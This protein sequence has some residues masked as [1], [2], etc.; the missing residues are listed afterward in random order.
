MADLFQQSFPSDF[1]QGLSF[2]CYLFLGNHIID[3]ARIGGTDRWTVSFAVWAPDAMAVQV[4]GSFNQWGQ[5]ADFSGSMQPVSDGIWHTEISGISDG[6]L[7]VYQITHKDGSVHRQMDPFARTCTLHPENASVIVDTSDFHWTDGDWKQARTAYSPAT[8]PINIYE[9]HL[10][11]WLRNAAYRNYRSIAD[12]LTHYLQDMHYTH[13]SLTSL[14]EYPYDSSFGYHVGCFYAVTGRYGTP[15][16]FKYLVNRLH[17]AGIGVLMDWVP[18][19]FVKDSNWLYRFGGDW[20]YESSIENFRENPYL[21]TISF[22][23]SKGPV[24]SFLISN[25]LFWL[26]E[27]H[28]DGLCIKS[29]E[30]VLYHDFGRVH[31][32]EPKNIYGGRENLE[33]VSFIRNLNVAI[34]ERFPGAITVADD[35]SNWPMVTKPVYLGGLGFDLNW[36]YPWNNDTLEYMGADPVYRS[37]LHG[38]MIIH[39]TND[40]SA[41]TILS[42]SHD[43]VACGKKSL[44]NKMFGRPSVRGATL[45]VYLTYLMTHPGKKLLFMGSEFGDENEW[46]YNGSLTWSLL[47]EPLHSGLQAYVRILNYI[48][49]QERSLWDCAQ[50]DGGF[51]WIDADN[52]SQNVFIYRRNSDRADDF[53]LIV[54]NFSDV[55]YPEYKIGVPRFADYGEL[56]NSEDT[57][58]GG[59]VVYEGKRVRPKPEPWN[60][61]PFHINV[62][63]PAC[64]A[65]IYKPFFPKRTHVS[66]LKRYELQKKE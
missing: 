58:F 15:Q 26:D 65:Q 36:N 63:L 33:G 66:K 49:K 22:D 37:Y 8:S 31:R 53:L 23:F 42:V 46:Q 57:R 28:L 11:S 1:S 43:D 56:L 12:A 35:K 21:G 64:S 16:D 19:Y 10:G 29:L 18:G 54:C 55:S 25:G 34:R 27:Y 60:G 59:N 32:V 5:D 38:K 7:Y 50:A 20:H 9:L 47:E 61:Q 51:S 44:I 52:A 4:I 40:F 14:C 24:Q 2:D 30:K 39:A 48:Y 17:E 13:V 3:T 45:K 6:D 41:R 62:S